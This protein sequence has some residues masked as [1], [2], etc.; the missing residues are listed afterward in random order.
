MRLVALAATLAVLPVL[1]VGACA[2]LTL[3]CWVLFALIP[4]SWSNVEGLFGASMLLAACLLGAVLILVAL[5]RRSGS[6]AAVTGRPW[7]AATTAMYSLTATTACVLT[8]FWPQHGA[9]PMTALA[10][11][12]GIVVLVLAVDWSATDRTPR[13]RV[14]AVV[15]ALA[16]AT[17][18]IAPLLPVDRGVCAVS[19]HG[20]DHSGTAAEYK[21][22]TD[23]GTFAVSAEQADLMA[24]TVGDVHII[25]RGFT[26]G[27]LPIPVVV[28]LSPARPLWGIGG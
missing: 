11:A 23:C 24:D 15:V 4:S 7:F 10:V 26:I 14:T 18:I 17:G 16:L 6:P 21:L 9:V 1:A 13:A 22:W 28:S 5:L 25:T 12:L 20:W 27:F 8:A 2:L 3:G 19:G